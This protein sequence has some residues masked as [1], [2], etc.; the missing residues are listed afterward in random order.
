MKEPSMA[1]EWWRDAEKE[2]A[3][4]MKPYSKIRPF[5]RK[6]RLTRPQVEKL[7][8]VLEQASEFMFKAA[9]SIDET[10]RMI[11]ISMGE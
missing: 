4:A 5:M 9:G 8:K 3:R 11:R 2:L 6:K 10:L 7:R 1:L